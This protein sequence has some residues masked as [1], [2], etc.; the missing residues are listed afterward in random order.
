MF[1]YHYI[2]SFNTETIV[3][4]L[5]SLRVKKYAIIFENTPTGSGRDLRGARHVR[6]RGRRDQTQ[7][8]KLT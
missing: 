7:L 2:I 6:Q 4:S 1:H 5:S 3:L 8:L